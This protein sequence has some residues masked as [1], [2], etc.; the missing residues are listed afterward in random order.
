MY[1]LD[2]MRAAVR[3]S[4]AIINSVRAAIG[5]WKPKNYV[6]RLESMNEDSSN[7][8]LYL[9]GIFKENNPEMLRDTKTLLRNSN[10]VLEDVSDRDIIAN[11]KTSDP[12]KEAWFIFAIATAAKQ[13]H[14]YKRT[15]TTGGLYVL[16][17]RLPETLKLLTKDALHSMSHNLLGQGKLVLAKVTT[18]GAATYLDIPGGD[19]SKGLADFEVGT[20]N[21]NWDDYYCD[22]SLEKILKK[23][24]GM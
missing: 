1:S 14:P 4:T 19:L 10:G 24:E 21:F 22:T 8:K 15:S 6:K 5:F 9:F 23:V 13:G 2:D 3:G 17:N 18:K 7:G 11:A 16:R 12:E 20:F